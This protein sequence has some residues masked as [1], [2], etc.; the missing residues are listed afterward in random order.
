MTGSR[1]FRLGEA[2]S[3]LARSVRVPSGN[4]PALM[5]RKRS[6]F[7]SADR[8]RNGPSLPGCVSVPRWAETSSAERSQ[9]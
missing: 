7:S 8:L 2:M 4:S 9:T 6:R 5:R 3:I 1:R